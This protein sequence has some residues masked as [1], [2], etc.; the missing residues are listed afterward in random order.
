MLKVHKMCVKEENI[1]SNHFSF[2]KKDELLIKLIMF[3][4][5]IDLKIFIFSFTFSF[6]SPLS[7]GEKGQAEYGRVCEPV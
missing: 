5:S 2:E 1:M 3:L 6:P 4:K 7:S